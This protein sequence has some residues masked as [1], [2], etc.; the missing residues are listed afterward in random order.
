MPGEE[1]LRRLKA[2]ET[3]REIPVIVLSADASQ[4]QRDRLLRAGANE[5]LTKPL[6]VQ[7]FLEAVAASLAGSEAALAREA[8]T[9]A[10]A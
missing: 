8:P 2:D 10:G 5:Y 1:V 9:V 7:G 6:D 4:R 3:T